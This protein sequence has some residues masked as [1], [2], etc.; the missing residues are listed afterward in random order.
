MWR[1]GSSRVAMLREPHT[2][3]ASQRVHSLFL[4]IAGYTKRLVIAQSAR[5]RSSR[6]GPE[7]R[8]LRHHFGERFFLR[9]DGFGLLSAG[10]LPRR[11]RWQTLFSAPGFCAEVPF[12]WARSTR[13]GPGCFAL[14]LGDTLPGMSGGR[15]GGRIGLGKGVGLK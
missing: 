11:R 14:P 15:G 13:F 2:T 6:S 9:G 5:S 7:I 8:E 12:A 10:P 3:K 4:A 1:G